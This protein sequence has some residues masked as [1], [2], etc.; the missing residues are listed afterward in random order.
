MSVPNSHYKLTILGCG[1][2][3]GVPRI[4]GNWGECD[5]DDPKNRR[6][7]CSLLVQRFDGDAVTNVLIDT[8]PDA[9][10]Q[11]LD[12]GV[13]WLDGVVITHEHA[14][15]THG[16][17]ELRVVAIN[18]RE[19]VKVYTNQATA[20]VLKM[21]F[22]YCFIQPEGSSY[23]PIL[24][25]N[26]IRSGDAFSID[27]PAGPITMT[28][29]D[30]IHGDIIS[31][32]L[33]I[34]GV[35]YSSDLNDVPDESLD[36]LRDLDVWIVDALRRKPHPSHFSLDESLKWIERLK[37]RQAILTNMHTDLDYQTVTD[38]TDDHI[39]AAYDMMTIQ[40]PN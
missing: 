2:S 11:L 13:G 30:Q 36:I 15:H 8:S 18:G 32:G 10:E 35:A 19:R 26:E 28:P 29:F 12:A 40:T 38:E 31:L 25:L 1:S 22:G 4:G 34:G 23:P 5:P 16:I 24:D 6:R 9:R 20:D 33:R 39:K 3:G 27:G 21:R 37:P 14:D 17:D 7:R